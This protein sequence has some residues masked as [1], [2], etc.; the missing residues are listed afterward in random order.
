MSEFKMLTNEEINSLIKDAKNGNED[1]KNKLLQGNYPLIKSI[2]KRFLNRGVDYDD[3]YQLGSLGFVKA[4]YN[5]DTNFNVKFSTYAVPMIAGE[6]KRFLRDDGIIKVSRSIK[7]L[8]LKINKYISECI[9]EGKSYT[10]CEI[11]E[12]FNV[13]KE[14]VVYAS[15]K[16]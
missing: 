16:Y 13:D 3:L 2:V 8:A 4:I 14:D 6:I 7:S 1:A 12:K 15:L 9:K 5:F 10:V 11:S